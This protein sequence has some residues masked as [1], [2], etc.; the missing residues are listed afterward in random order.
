[1]N[2]KTVAVVVLN[3]NGGDDIID[4]LESVFRSKHVPVEVVIV[5]NGSVDGSTEVIPPLSSGALDQQ[6]S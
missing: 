3:W 2:E 5:D 4:C 1:M 6:S